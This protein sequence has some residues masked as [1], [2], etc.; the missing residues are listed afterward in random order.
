MYGGG[1]A[2]ATY[3]YG[4]DSRMCDVIGRQQRP[5]RSI[6]GEPSDIKL[7]YLLC[8]IKNRT[9]TMEFLADRTMGS[10]I[11]NIQDDRLCAAAVMVALKA[12][13]KAMSSVISHQKFHRLDSTYKA[14]KRECK[15]C[16][17]YIN[18]GT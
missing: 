12:I 8:N 14:I 4:A 17:C 15:Y 18:I 7:K 3:H 6:S 11:R 16:D 10:H 1:V 9:A 13:G 5:E 2:A